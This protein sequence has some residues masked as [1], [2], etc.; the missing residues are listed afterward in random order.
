LELHLHVFDCWV[1]D[2]AV[3]VHW[4][5]LDHFNCFLC[6]S[7]SDYWLLCPHCD[8]L[9]QCAVY[10]HRFFDNSLDFNDLG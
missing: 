4:Y 8:P 2:Y 5:L 3:D 7:L 10:V 9:L 6:V 1:V